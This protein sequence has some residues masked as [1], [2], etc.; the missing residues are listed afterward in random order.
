[1]THD[2]TADRDAVPLNEPRSLT[3]AVPAEIRVYGHS[4]LFYW[5]PAWLFGFAAAMV[6]AGQER[7]LSA[8][9]T[10]QAGSALGLGYVTLLIL[11]IIF[12]NVRLRGIYSIVLLISVA[13]IVVL[14][15]WFD[16]WENIIRMIPYLSVRMNTDFYMVFSTA[17]FC[18]WLLMFF[19]FDRT[20]YWRIRPGQMTIEHVIGGGA[21]SFDTNSLRFQKL[22]SDLF[23][24]LLGLGTGDLQAIV[25]GQ[26]GTTVTISNVVFAA[27][28]VQAI[29][30]LIAVK[31][32]VAA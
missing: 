3:V 29:E 18:I 30:K 22:N 23:R 11:L 2:L 28:K 7:L 24:A 25:G 19:V 17:L 27:R 32:D 31:P 9:G 15:A 26:Y 14:F 10:Q 20:T 16:W 1:M 12:T 4:T 13:F 21:E 6:S 8:S 5:W